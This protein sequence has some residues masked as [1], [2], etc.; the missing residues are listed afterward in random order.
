MLVYI[1]RKRVTDDKPKEE[2]VYRMNRGI[3]DAIK[4]GVPKAYVEE[5]M[6]PFIPAEKDVK[7]RKSLEEKEA[8]GGVRG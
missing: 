7:G 4:M 2:Y 3:D 8:G 6:R 1:D 5:V